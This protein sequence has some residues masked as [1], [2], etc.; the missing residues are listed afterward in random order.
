MGRLVY[1]DD[2]IVWKYAFGEQASELYRVPK[3]TGACQHNFIKID[4]GKV[5]EDGTIEWREVDPASEEFDGDI[6]KIGPPDIPALR[7]Y[8]EE[9]TPRIGVLQR[10]LGKSNPLDHFTA[11]VKAIADYAEGK[12]NIVL[13]GEM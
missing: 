8:V 1:C 7:R 12:G 11:M 2:E 3:E 5:L 13:R 4:D 9:N 10:I 6:L